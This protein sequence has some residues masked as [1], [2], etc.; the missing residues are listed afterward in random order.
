MQ[1]K[2]RKKKKRAII[3]HMQKIIHLQSLLSKH[4]DKLATNGL[5]AKTS[6][7]S[8]KIFNKEA[9]CFKI[10]EVKHTQALFILFLVQTNKL[11]LIIRRAFAIGQLHNND[12]IQIQHC[13]LVSKIIK[14]T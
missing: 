3:E 2:K 5:S 1:A 12:C 8:G 10:R 11:K 9:H 13:L 14:K 6:N 4:I 7:L